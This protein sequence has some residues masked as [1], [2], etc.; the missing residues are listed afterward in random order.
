MILTKEQT[1]KRL[2]SERN[3]TNKISVVKSV[4]SLNEIQEIQEIQEESPEIKIKSVVHSTGSKVGSKHLT[5]NERIAI[6][7]LANTID[8]KTVG[9]IFNISPSHVSDLKNANRNV[10]GRIKDIDLQAKVNERLDKTKLSIQERAAEK[11][12]STLGLFDEPEVKD[13]LKNS[14]PKEISQVSSQ[15]SQVMRNMNQSNNERDTGKA[16]VSIIMHQPKPSNE[17]SF[18]VIEIGI[19]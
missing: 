2:N 8:H 18:D 17:S 6:S 13:K 14:S 7:V 10:N 16:K 11:L 5:E 1:E 15:L 12:L 9:E 4:S 19:D 3:I